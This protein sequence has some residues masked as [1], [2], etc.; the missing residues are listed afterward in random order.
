MLQNRKLAIVVWSKSLLPILFYIV[1]MVAI[2]VG[3]NATYRS[4][5][6]VDRVY[7]SILEMKKLTSDEKKLAE[8]KDIVEDNL[9]RLNWMIFGTTIVEMGILLYFLGSVKSG[10]AERLGQIARDLNQFSGEIAQTM[11]LQEQNTAQQAA[12]VNQTTTTMDELS[13]SSQQSAE[14]AG[15]AAIEANQGLS[16]AESGLKAVEN[17]ESVMSMLSSKVNEMQVQIGNLTEKTNQ[18]GNISKLVADLASQTNMLAL[19]AAVEA[20]RAGEHGK[21]FS[22]VAQEIRKL[23]D[24]SKA[25]T[26]SIDDLVADIQMAI[27]STVM[28]TQEG[29]RTVE[30][31]VTIARDTAETFRGLTEAIDN[32]SL[33]VQQISLNAKQQALAIQQVVDTMSNINY[34]AAQTA[35]SI[36]QVKQGSE[37]LNHMIQSLQ[38]M[39]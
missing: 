20:V 17:T 19:N 7:E 31:G 12:A 1:Q 34:T 5:T 39:V 13:A 24:Q 23:A 22:V 32:I 6:E 35:T 2:G 25:S 3:L 8:K 38:K 27:D 21:G 10:I 26:A 11:E 16:L 4:F 33:S 15:A 29:R 14:Q 36:S 28:V 9:S 37:K 30:H 18:I